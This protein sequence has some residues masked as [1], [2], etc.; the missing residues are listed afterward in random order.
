MADQIP[1]E[2]KAKRPSKKEWAEQLLKK[3]QT[4]LDEGKSGEEALEMLTERQYDFLIDYGVDLDEVILSPEQRRNIGE[5]MNKGA[6]RPTFPNG[7][8]KKY[9]PKKRAFFDKLTDFILEQGGEIRPR[10][11]CNYRNIEFD[12]DGDYYEIVFSCPP[13]K[14]GK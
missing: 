11:K 14:Q 8:N 12:L 7:Y 13:K 9:P 5:L 2:S 1:Y 10:P 4:A 3:I 6:G